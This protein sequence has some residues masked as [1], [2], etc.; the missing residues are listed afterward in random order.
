MDSYLMQEKLKSSYF[1]GS[2]PPT[3]EEDIPHLQLYAPDYSEE[4]AAARRERFMTKQHTISEKMQLYNCSTQGRI[5]ELQRLLNDEGY[6]CTEEVSKEGHFWTVLHYA[7]HYGHYRVLE[8][9]VNYLE[10]NEN[11]FE[12][13]NMQTLEGKTPLF[14]AIL[15]CDIKQGQVKKDIIKLLFDTG[16]MDLSLRKGSGEDLL[17]LARRNHLYDYIVTQCLRED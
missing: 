16:K 9:L 4:N 15:S 13:L 11:S 12:I 6:S 3:A 2:A 17:D 5:E 7:S 8:F 1:A 10:N 14:C